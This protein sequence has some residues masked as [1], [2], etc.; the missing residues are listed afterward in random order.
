MLIIEWLGGN[1]PV[2]AEGTIDGKPFYF[3]ARGRWWSL[4]IADVTFREER[5]GD[6]EFAAGWMPHD[7]ARKLIERCAND[8]VSEHTG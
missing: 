2:Q 6:S 8:Y 3:R 1:C 7:E 5:W 4:E